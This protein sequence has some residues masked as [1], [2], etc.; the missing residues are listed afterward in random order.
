MDAMILRWLLY[1]QLEHGVVCVF[2]MSHFED[3]SI[4]TAAC[5][6]GA[7]IPI[8]GLRGL[9][10]KPEEI[11]ANTVSHLATQAATCHTHLPDTSVGLL[12]LSIQGPS[13]L[14]DLWIFI[15]L[16]CSYAP[17]S[18]SRDNSNP[19]YQPPSSRVRCLRRHEAT[20]TQSQQRQYARVPNRDTAHSPRYRSALSLPSHR[21]GTESADAQAPGTSSYSV[22]EIPLSLKVNALISWLLTGACIRR[23][24]RVPSLPPTISNRYLCR[25]SRIPQA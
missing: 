24:A 21:C 8:A 7:N 22:G 25:T 13:Q 4:D 17:F 11:W 10:G 23:P 20:E 18:K 16:L 3:H 1:T 2:L 12:P 6:V 9:A 14:F 5:C 19:T 15:V